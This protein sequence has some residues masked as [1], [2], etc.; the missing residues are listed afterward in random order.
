MNETALGFD[1][2]DTLLEAW[3]F[4]SSYS[5]G[6]GLDRKLWMAPGTRRRSSMVQNSNFLRTSIGTIRATYLGKVRS[7]LAKNF[8][9]SGLRLIYLM[10]SKHW[11]MRYP[12]RDTVGRVDCRGTTIRYD[13]GD[14]L[15]EYAARLRAL[16]SLR[17]I[18]LLQKHAPIYFPSQ[19]VLL[20]WLKE[21]Q[22]RGRRYRSCICVRRR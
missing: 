21:A 14:M 15:P 19:K 11:R 12:P 3:H 9:V 6:F 1:A 18:D 2:L 8:R 17:P 5:F 22:R 13:A 20:M 16:E 4:S 7:I 10:N